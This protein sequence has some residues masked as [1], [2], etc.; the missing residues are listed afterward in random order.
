MGE[1]FQPSVTCVGERCFC[2]KPAAKKVG[3]EIPID[4]PQPYRHNLT[5]YVCAEH[6]AQLMGPLGAQQVGLSALT[7]G[8]MQADVGVTEEMVS[9]IL[10]YGGR[11]RDC[12][13]FDGFC[14]GDG[15]PCEPDHARKIIG[16][17]LKA[18]RHFNWGENK[19]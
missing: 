16:H 18:E 17:V 14:Q 5:A 8:V 11:C 12:A 7:G 10:R 2:G 3:E 1:A 6:Y 19:S 4:D 13:D 15:L 9:H